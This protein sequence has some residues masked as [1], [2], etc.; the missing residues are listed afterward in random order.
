MREIDTSGHAGLARVIRTP[1]DELRRLMP[2]RYDAK[3]YDTCLEQCGVVHPTL[4][5]PS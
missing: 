4:E 3:R 5:P 2:F 1:L